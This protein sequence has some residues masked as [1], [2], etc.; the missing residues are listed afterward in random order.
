MEC[1]KVFFVTHLGFMVKLGIMKLA[2]VARASGRSS[3]RVFSL[4]AHDW[5]Q[6]ELGAMEDQ[7]DQ[8]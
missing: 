6:G 4:A 5:L 8:K 1:H 2:A 3:T 7:G